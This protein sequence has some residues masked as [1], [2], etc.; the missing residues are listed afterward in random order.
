MGSAFTVSRVS[1]VRV[2]VA[3]V[4]PS[5]EADAVAMAVAGVGTGCSTTAS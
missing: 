1:T 5:A 4:A 2:G 3:G